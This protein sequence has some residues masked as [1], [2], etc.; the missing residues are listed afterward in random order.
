MDDLKRRDIAYQ[1]ARATTT[2]EQWLSVV[3]FGM[4]QL[5][6]DHELLMELI[7]TEADRYAGWTG[8]SVPSAALLTMRELGLSFHSKTPNA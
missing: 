7:V 2:H 8:R 6:S 4:P 5:L 3:V 1:L